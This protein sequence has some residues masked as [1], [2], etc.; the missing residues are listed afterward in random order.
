MVTCHYK[1]VV[2]KERPRGTAGMFWRSGSDSGLIIANYQS[3]LYNYSMFREMRR[4]KQMVSQEECIRILSEEKRGVLSVIGDEGYPYG[5]PVNFLYD[6]TDNCIYFHCAKSGHKLDSILKC[7][8]VCFTVHDQGYQ[9]DDWSFYVT[10]VIAFGR[11][12]VMEDGDLKL[13]KAR[14]FGAKYYPTEEELEAELS[15]A[16]NRANLICIRIEH[17]TGKLVHEK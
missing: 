11:A 3:N 7:D 5:V 15:H 1:S 2:D 13:Q 10:S 6:K 17:M 8:K 4:F 9:K 14:Q 12:H 16:Y